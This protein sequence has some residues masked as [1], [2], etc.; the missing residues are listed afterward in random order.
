MMLNGKPMTVQEFLDMDQACD[1]QTTKLMQ[2]Q[3]PVYMALLHWIVKRRQD[4]SL[5]WETYKTWD[6]D[7]E[8]IATEVQVGE[9]SLENG[10]GPGVRPGSATSGDSAGVNTPAL[11]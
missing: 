11:P 5:T 4:R 3:S 8:K 9:P 1:Y 2:N 10:T 6:L 7:L